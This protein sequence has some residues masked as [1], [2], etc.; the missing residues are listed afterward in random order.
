MVLPFESVE[1]PAPVAADDDPA[2][3]PPELCARA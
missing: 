3:V 2:D 1:P